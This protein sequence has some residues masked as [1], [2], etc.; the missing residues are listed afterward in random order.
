MVRLGILSQRD[1]H[2]DPRGLKS[3]DKCPYKGDTGDDGKMER[4]GHKP[5]KLAAPRSWKKQ[6][7]DFRLKPP[8]RGGPADSLIWDF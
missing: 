8:R 6:G 1:H 7:T 2:D 3:N 5:R 4:C